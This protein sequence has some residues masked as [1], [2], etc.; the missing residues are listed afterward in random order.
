M[1]AWA[2]AT[3]QPNPARPTRAANGTEPDGEHLDPDF[4]VSGNEVVSQLVHEDE[5]RENQ[6]EGDHPLPDIR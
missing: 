1:V 3:T 4:V 6:E 2:N 5:D